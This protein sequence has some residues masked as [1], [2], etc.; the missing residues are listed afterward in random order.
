MHIDN[1]APKARFR[2][3]RSVDERLR[4]ALLELAENKATVLAHDE[5]NWASVTFAGARHRVE[6]RFEGAEAVDA[7]ERFIALLPEHEFALPGHL[8]ADAALTEVSHRLDPAC[9]T[10]HCELLLIEGD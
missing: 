5:A 1:P 3:R 4:E 9:M 10:V 2:S 6:L 8:V 7:G